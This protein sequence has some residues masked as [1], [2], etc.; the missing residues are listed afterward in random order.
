M[1][2]LDLSVGHRG[3]LLQ[4]VGN[5]ESHLRRVLILLGQVVHHYGEG[6]AVTDLR[7]TRVAQVLG[8]GR[9]STSAGR[10]AAY[11]GCCLGANC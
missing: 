1:D 11:D 8:K 4:V 3:L 9:D 10:V 2:A 6:L 7:R 5:L